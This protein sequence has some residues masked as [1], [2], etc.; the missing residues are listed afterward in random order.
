LLA[1][2]QQSFSWSEINFDKVSGIMKGRFHLQEKLFRRRPSQALPTQL[3]A[4]FDALS[5]ACPNAVPAYK[6]PGHHAVTGQ[7]A[8]TK[9][10]TP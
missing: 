3:S 5:R 1:E 8:K 2:S 9:G 6:N 4:I 10:A 7:Y